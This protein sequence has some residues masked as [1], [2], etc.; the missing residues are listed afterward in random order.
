V[1]SLEPSAGYCRMR[2]FITGN[3]G[4]LGSAITKR[5]PLSDADGGDLPNFDITSYAATRAAIEASK[6]DVVIHC[7]AYTNV[8]GCAENPEMAYQIN[9]LGTQNM[10][11]A[12]AETDTAMMLVSTNEVFDG[13]KTTSYW[14]FDQRQPINSYGQ[15]K[16]AAERYV[17]SLLN[18]FYIVRTSWLYAAGG[19]NF[20]HRI[21]ELADER[22]ELDVVADELGVPTRTSDLAQGILNLISTDR[23][24]IYHL[25]NSIAADE[26]PSRWDFAKH[27]LE[28]SGRKNFSLNKIK[29]RDYNR[30]SSPPANG[31]LANTAAKAL[32]IELPNWQTA[33]EE[34]LTA[35]AKS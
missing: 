16:Y 17:E 34:F 21:Q 10:A 13:T 26:M 19:K 6:A 1:Y 33:L 18:K 31:V 20:V 5:L 29:L 11:L 8:D 4:Q 25:T 12:C 7:A 3:K 30:V 2:Y 9:G 32:G 23:Y 28:A 14:E 15:S 24:G 22:G 35:S 27:A